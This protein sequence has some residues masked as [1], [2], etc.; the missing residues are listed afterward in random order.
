[1]L[2]LIG[3]A[4]LLLLVLVASLHWR[5]IATVGYAGRHGQCVFFIGS[6]LQR[7]TK[8][9][10]AQDLEDCTA[11]CSQTSTC[12][13]VEWQED[14]SPSGSCRLISSWPLEPDGAGSQGM[15]SAICFARGLP[16]F[17]PDALA[18]ISAGVARVGSGSRDGT[19]VVLRVQ[20]SAFL[21]RMVTALSTAFGIEQ[22]DLDAIPTSLPRNMSFSPLVAQSQ[23]WPSTAG[24]HLRRLGEESKEQLLKKIQALEKKVRDLRD[25]NCLLLNNTGVEACEDY[26]VHEPDVDS[27][28]VVN[29]RRSLPGANVYWTWEVWVISGL[30]GLLALAGASS[31][32]IWCTFLSPRSLWKDMS[33]MFSR[34][35]LSYQ[36]L[37]SNRNADEMQAVGQVLQR[38][39]RLRMLMPLLIPAI[40][41]PWSTCDGGAPWWGYALAAASL[42]RA[43]YYEYRILRMVT[44]SGWHAM[45]TVY[46]ACGVVDHLDWFTAGTFCVQAYKCEPTATTHF[47]DMMATTWLGPILPALK[48]IRF[49]SLIMASTVVTMIIQQTLGSMGKGISA[50]A[51]AAEIA[52][53]GAVSHHYSSLEPEADRGLVKVVTAFSK[54]LLKN[55]CQLWLQSSFFGMAFDSLSINGKAKL[56]LA[57]ALG[58]GCAIFKTQL[59]ATVRGQQLSASL[60]HGRPDLALIILAIL[61]VQLAT[62]CLALW[63]V[64]KIY[65]SYAC[66]DHLWSI[67][68]GC[69]EHLS[70]TF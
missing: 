14:S 1:M 19:N 20:Q 16:N 11:H 54:V 27:G 57:M 5:P 56:L 28:G 53:F 51:S 60:Y 29:L 65:K 63:T 13:A 64:V 6:V 30:F 25:Y 52:S 49:W 35:V 41:F 39:M 44:K 23:N 4:V 40:T 37:P 34:G 47:L 59:A 45:F 50:L 32:C 24:Q 3:P 22:S 12:W 69:V 26:S 70:Q 42:L 17:V 48:A 62:W 7:G 67:W 8:H 43:K 18:N 46:F 21:L 61:L 58:I 31:S 9:P 36:S 15:T 68:H 2:V 55:A 38:E 10:R 33:G 66:P